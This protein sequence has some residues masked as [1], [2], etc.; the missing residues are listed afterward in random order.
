MI[1]KNE[2]ISVFLFMRAFFLYIYIYAYMH[3]YNI[4]KIQYIVKNKE[5]FFPIFSMI[6]LTAL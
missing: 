3:I 1:I 2:H 5:S 6:Q 4:T